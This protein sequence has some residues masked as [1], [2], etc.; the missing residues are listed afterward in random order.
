MQLVV[1]GVNQLSPTAIAVFAGV[2]S[3]RTSACDGHL[4]A[5]GGRCTV[6][7]EH[8]LCLCPHPF[9]GWHCDVAGKSIGISFFNF[10]ER[11]T[12]FCTFLSRTAHYRTRWLQ[13]DRLHEI[14][15]G[16]HY[17]TVSFLTL[18]KIARENHRRRGA[19]SLY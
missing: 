13:C 18:Q 9:T 19:P 3:C 15:T 6:R 12:T 4:C 8:A 7:H 14:H 1:N 10:F 5:N 11:N 16:A 2:H 17:E